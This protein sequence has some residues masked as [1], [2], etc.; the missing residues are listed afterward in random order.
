VQ[1][2]RSHESALRDLDCNSKWR[3]VKFLILTISFVEEHQKGCIKLQKSDY[4]HDLSPSCHG[5]LMDTLVSILVKLVLT[6]F[7]YHCFNFY[8]MLY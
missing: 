5:K 3:S 1:L 6:I 2:L 4:P 7:I 8:Y